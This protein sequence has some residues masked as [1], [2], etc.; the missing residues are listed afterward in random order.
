VTDVDCWWPVST[1]QTRCIAFS[2]LCQSNERA[3]EV[4]HL[5]ARCAALRCAVISARRRPA[6][7]CR[8]YELMTRAPRLTYY[9][10][11]RPEFYRQGHSHKSAADVRRTMWMI[12]R[13][14]MSKDDSRNPQGRWRWIPQGVWGAEVTC[15]GRSISKP[16]RGL[17]RSWNIFVTASINLWNWDCYFHKFVE[18]RNTVYQPLCVWKWGPWRSTRDLAVTPWHGFNDATGNVRQREHEKINDV[19]ARLQFCSI[20]SL[21][22]STQQSQHFSLVSRRSAWTCELH[23]RRRRH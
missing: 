7:R 13:F 20:R 6:T 5:A 1:R 10:C 4:W 3:S 23:A 11:L 9:V 16:A 18:K 8:F 15:T 14:V 12:E 19:L 17:G 21:G 2:V 22:L